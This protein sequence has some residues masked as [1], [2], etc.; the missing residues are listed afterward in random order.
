MGFENAEE[1]VGRY[2]NRG[3]L[4]VISLNNG[5]L[6]RGENQF[7]PIAGRRY[8]IPAS[9]TTMYFRR[10]EAGEVDAIIS[11]SGSRESVLPRL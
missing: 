11:V 4:A 8:Y 9:G 10:N 5:E 1:L 6:F 3:G 7:Y 2:D